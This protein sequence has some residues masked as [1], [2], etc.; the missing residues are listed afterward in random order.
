MNAVFLDTVGLITLWDENDQWHAAAEAAYLQI[1]WRRTL[2]TTTFVVLE[3]G[4]TA[5]RRPFRPHVVAL[6]QT[7]EQRQELIVPTAEDW[8]NAW[9]AYE[10]GEA[11]QAGI[12]DHVSFSV[13]RRLGQTQAFTNERHFL[14]CTTGFVITRPCARGVVRFAWLAGFARMRREVHPRSGGR[15]AV[16]GSLRHPSPTRIFPFPSRVG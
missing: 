11:G 16:A 10:R 13:M 7:L 2:V 14:G 9:Q 6:R 8:A 5:A 3:C 12:V 4:N 15:H 1:G